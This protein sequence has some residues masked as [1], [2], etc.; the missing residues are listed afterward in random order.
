MDKSSGTHPACVPV[1]SVLL[2]GQGVAS[3]AVRGGTEVFRG[4][5][6]AL[7]VAA[8]GLLMP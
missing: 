6:L 8:A 5:R 4:T 1:R 3:W 7:L 2:R